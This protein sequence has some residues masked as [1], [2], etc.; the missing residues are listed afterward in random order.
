MIRYGVFLVLTLYIETDSSN[1]FLASQSNSIFLSLLT[2]FSSS[3][4]AKA[5]A[6]FLLLQNLDFLKRGSVSIPE[7]FGFGSSPD[8]RVLIPNRYQLAVSFL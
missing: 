6:V 5:V 3:S 8:P 2:Q 1:P 7:L 4:I